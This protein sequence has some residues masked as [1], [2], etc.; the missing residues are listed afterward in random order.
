MKKKVQIKELRE[1]I[2]VKS[3][4]AEKFLKESKD[5]KDRYYVVPLVVE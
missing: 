4:D 2:V 3:P 1:D 5:V